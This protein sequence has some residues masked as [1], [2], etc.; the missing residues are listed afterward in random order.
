VNTVMNIWS[1]K[2]GGGV[3]FLTIRESKLS[4]NSA[5]NFS[6]YKHVYGP[7]INDPSNITLL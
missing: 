7:C 3:N 5:L 4:K 6:V 1:H 2:R